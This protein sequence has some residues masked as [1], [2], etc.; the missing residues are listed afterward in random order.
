LQLA[1]LH[2]WYLRRLH[3][4]RP[5]TVLGGKVESVLHSEALLMWLQY[6]LIKFLKEST[7]SSRQRIPTLFN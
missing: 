4:L 5:L 7:D 6:R 1:E 2:S 3:P